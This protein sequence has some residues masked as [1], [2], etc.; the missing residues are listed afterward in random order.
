MAGEQAGAF[1]FVRGQHV[2]Q[3]QQFARHRHVR[4]RG[5]EDRDASG[6]ARQTQRRRDRVQRRF[7]LRQGHGR[8]G[9]G[10]RLRFDESCCE[11]GV[12][13]RADDDAVAALGIDEDAGAAGGDIGGL[14]AQID[15]VRGGQRARV[16]AAQVI[17]QRADECGACAA[18][19]R[20]GGLVEA[21]AAGAAGVVAAEGGAGLRQGVAAPDVIDVERTDDDDLGRGGTGG[22]F[23]HFFS[24]L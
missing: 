8:R 22:Q 4:R 19:R 17:A 2:G 21:L 14:V 9:D 5:V 10:L 18:A 23:R 20:R 1:G 12:G 13:A 11:R 15:A 6:L 3:R 24:K 16:V 7:Q